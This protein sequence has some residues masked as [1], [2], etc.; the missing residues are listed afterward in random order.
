MDEPCLGYVMGLYQVGFFTLHTLHQVICEFVISQV[1]ETSGGAQCNKAIMIITDG[2]PDTFEK[3]FEQY[4][5]PNKD[6]STNSSILIYVAIDIINY[7]YHVFLLS[8][9]V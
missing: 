7:Y 3:I 2:A 5:W 1:N 6:A 4:N 9:C 8:S